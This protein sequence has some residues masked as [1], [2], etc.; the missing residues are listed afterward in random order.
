MDGMKVV[1][2]QQRD[3]GGGCKT[4][5]E[6]LEGWRALV[7][8]KVIKFNVVILAWSC[9]LLNRPP[10]LWWIVTY[11]RVGCRYMMRLG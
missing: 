9:V 11:M 1:L 10:M 8:M 4:M 2:G 7:H 3:D 5:L 6:K